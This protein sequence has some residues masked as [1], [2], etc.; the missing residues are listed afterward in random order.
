MTLVV[1]WVTCLIWSSVWLFIKL[2]LRDLPPVTF[3]PVRLLVALAIMLPVLAIRRVP[4]PRQARD[5]Y[6][7]AVAG[8]LLLGVNYALL[9]W[10]AQF[11]PSGLTAVLQAMTPAFALVFGHFML[12]DEPFT[13]KALGAI[14]VGVAGVALISWDELHVAGRA[15]LLGC[16][17]VT[18]ASVVVGFA[19]AF[20]QRHR[21]SLTPDARSA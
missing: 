12:R 2:G 4:W 6:V 18:A 10:G 3:A 11:I 14:A 20:V 5:W 19:Y 15:A 17:A 21:R 1:W 9:F 7:V 8:V 13:W 16:L